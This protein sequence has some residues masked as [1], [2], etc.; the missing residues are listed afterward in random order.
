MVLCSAAVQT[1]L[2]PA[3]SS[4]IESS[5]A[6]VSSSS[7]ISPPPDSS[8]GSAVTKTSAIITP[9]HRQSLVNWRTTSVQDSG[10]EVKLEKVRRSFWRMETNRGA[11]VALALGII[12]TTLLLVLAGCRLR[13][14]RKR[15]RKGRHLN[16]NEADYLINGMYL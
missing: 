7:T 5:A 14:F 8:S 11:V 13:H 16:S 4:K 2:L 10:V 9:T 1:E 12:L 6:A 3:V 15:S